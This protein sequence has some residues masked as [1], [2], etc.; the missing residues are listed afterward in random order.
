MRSQHHVQLICSFP[1]KASEH[2][3]HFLQFRV[4]PIPL[5][6]VNWKIQLLGER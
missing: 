6:L 1:R 4:I 5:V 3:T 2:L